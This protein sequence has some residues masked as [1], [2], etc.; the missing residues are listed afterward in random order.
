MNIAKGKIEAPTVKKWI[1]AEGIDLVRIADAQNLILAHPPRPATTLMPSAR[2]V[3]VMSVAHSLG[4]VYSPDIMLWTRNKMQ[5]SRLLDE[6]E[7]S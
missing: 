2:S 3:I 1:Q 4:V 6:G 5:T 7:S